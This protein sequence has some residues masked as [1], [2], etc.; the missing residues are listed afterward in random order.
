MKSDPRIYSP[1]PSSSLAP[2]VNVNTW[3]NRTSRLVTLA[4][5]KTASSSDQRK[6]VRSG[7]DEWGHHLS[8]PVSA[9]TC[10][11]TDL[12]TMKGDTEC[13]FFLQIREYVRSVESTIIRGNKVMSAKPWKRPSLPQ[14]DKEADKASF[15]QFSSASSSSRVVQVKSAQNEAFNKNSEVTKL[16]KPPQFYFGQPTANGDVRWV[17]GSPDYHG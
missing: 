15:P 8:D 11:T 1:P 13:L 7:E 3:D 5:H 10:M 2:S 4:G 6:Y 12:V 17:N 14:M 16:P 9:E